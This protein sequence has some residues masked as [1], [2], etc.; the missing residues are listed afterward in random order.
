MERR[1]TAML[2]AFALHNAEGIA[3]ADRGARPDARF[4]ARLRLTE[5]D[6]RPERMS[7]AMVIL[8]AAVT[9]ATCP[10]AVLRQPSSTMAGMTASGALAVN[11]V[12]HLVLAVSRRQCN[13]GLA[14]APLLLATST[15]VLRALRAASSLPLARMGFAVG[16]GAMLSV[17]AIAASLRVARVLS[18]APALLVRMLPLHR[19]PRA[20]LSRS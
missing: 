13:P 16:A 9:V 12:G 8:T 4:V 5:D 1:R 11:A 17:P 3:F 6:Y 20:A 2:V 14:T 15:A 10:G 7:I 18:P 19:S